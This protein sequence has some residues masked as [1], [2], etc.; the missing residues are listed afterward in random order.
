MILHLY[1][2]KGEEAVAELDGMFAFALWDARRRRLLLARDRAGKKPLFYHDGP[3]LFAFASEIKALLAHPEVPHERDPEALP[4]YLTYGYVP[5]PGTFYRGIR[6]LPP[7]HSLVATE[8]G[9][10][11]PRRYWRAR[12]RATAPRS[13]ER[14]RG[15]GALPR[16]CCRA[17][18]SAGWWPTCRSGRSSRAGS[19]RRPSWR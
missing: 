5:T 1:E 6:S 15:R 4:L 3:R 9:A 14:R 19:T 11:E 7:A 17:P 8:A 13:A 16:R 10:E 12:F 18:S 2:E